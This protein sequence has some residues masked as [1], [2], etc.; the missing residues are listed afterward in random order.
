MLKKDMLYFL[1]FVCR[2]YNDCLYEVVLLTNGIRDVG[3]R[4]MFPRMLKNKNKN[5]FG[6]LMK[7][8]NL[9]SIVKRHEEANQK[10]KDD[11]LEVIK[12]LTNDISRRRSEHPQWQEKHA[13][14]TS[15]PLKYDC[16]KP[17]CQRMDDHHTE[18]DKAGLSPVTNKTQHFYPNCNFCLAIGVRNE[19]M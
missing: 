11:I 14:N 13:S 16:G 7:I 18:T 5:Y 1:F 6:L 3:I 10:F 8:N 9:T 17:H 4:H 19:K 12:K 2:D 15:R